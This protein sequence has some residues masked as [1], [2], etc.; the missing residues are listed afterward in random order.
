MT[1]TE[2]LDSVTNVE[3]LI[4]ICRIEGL[5]ALDDVY[6]AAERDDDIYDEIS[7]YDGSWRD[8]YDYLGAIPRGYGYYIKDRESWFAYTPVDEE[9][10]EDLKYSVATE[11]ENCGLWEVSDFVEESSV[12]EDQ[13]WSEDDSGDITILLDG[14]FDNKEW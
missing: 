1:R 10:F 8:L 6:N 11:M 3:Q 5:S 4:T 14:L 7:E 2:F 12:S 9:V 13:E